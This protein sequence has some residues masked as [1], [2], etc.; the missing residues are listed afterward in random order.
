[1]CSPTQTT[2]SRQDQS[3]ARRFKNCQRK[4]RAKQLPL[5]L[6]VPSVLIMLQQMV[7][8]ALILH[9]DYYN[10]IRCNNIKHK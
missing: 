10:E 6:L 1:M 2:A 8:V 3:N 9:Y 4:S 5:H 7:V